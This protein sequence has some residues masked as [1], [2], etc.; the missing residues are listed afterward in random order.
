MEPVAYQTIALTVEDGVCTLTLNRPEKLNALD[1][2]MRE[3]L[4]D[5]IPRV[6][7]DSAIGALLITGSGRAFS[8]G[9]DIQ[10][11]RTFHPGHGWSDIKRIHHWL[12]LLTRMDKPVVAALNGPVAGGGC[13]IALAADIVLA[14]EK[15]R[16]IFANLRLGLVPDG[17]LCYFLPRLVGLARARQLLLE[18]QDLTADAAVKMGLIAEVVPADDLLPRAAAL[19]RRL[20]HG[21]QPATGL[22]KFLLSKSQ[23]SDLESMLVHEANSLYLC[24][25]SPDLQEGLN[26]YVERREPRFGHGFAH[27]TQSDWR[28]TK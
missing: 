25:D 8:A 21:P 28:D 4:A 11:L 26:A 23:E 22:T 12:A 14:S 3:E 20:A 16:F 9:G 1:Q 24:F 10:R 18:S 13:G 2:Q 17:G 5:A 27:P 15:A 6:A 19:A 7:E